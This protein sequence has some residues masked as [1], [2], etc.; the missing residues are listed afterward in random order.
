MKAFRALFAASVTMLRRNRVLLITSL[1]LALLSIFVFGWLFGSSGTP[2]LELGVVDYDASP[3]SQQMTQRLQASDSLQVFRGTQAEELQALRDGHRNAVIVLAHGFA[4]ALTQGH[5]TSIQVY[6]DQSSP[7]MAANARMAVQSIVA[8]LNQQVTHQLPV[9]TLDEQAVSVH[10]LRQ[11]DWLTP[12][13]LGMLLMWANLSVGVVLVQWRQQGVLRRLAVTPLQSGVLISTQML[14]RLVLSLLQGAALIAVAMLV[15][16]VQVTGS[17]LAL[18]VT[19]AL[20]ALALQ[21]VGFVVGSFARTPEI[22]NAAF[23]LISFPMMFLSGSYFPTDSAPGFLSPVI[24]AM[25][26]T[27]LND[28]LRQIINNGAAL[29]AIP[30][31]LLIIAA[32]LVV[33]VVLSARAFR[34][35]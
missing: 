24:K 22:A 13:M 33:A 17:W 35:S 2:K 29:G 16:G 9:V 31:D 32:W 28:A 4:Q 34:W 8:D 27:Y 5:P 23:F 30:L 1:G 11:I 20:G 19:V 18:G 21:G 25:P 6:Y 15:F 7:V 14:A 10:E 12:G 3:L 26:L